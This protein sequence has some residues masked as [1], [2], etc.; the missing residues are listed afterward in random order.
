MT[1][2]PFTEEAE[3]LRFVPCWLHA[4]LKMA[5]RQ[6][7]K[8]QHNRKYL[9]NSATQEISCEFGYLSATC[10]SAR[11]RFLS[12]I[13]GANHNARIVPRLRCRI[14]DA[15]V[16]QSPASGGVGNRADDF[17]LQRATSGGGISRPSAFALGS[18]S[19]LYSRT[20]RS[21]DGQAIEHRQAH[22]LLLAGFAFDFTRKIT[23]PLSADN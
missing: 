10:R 23:T 2:L 19:A 11:A 18:Q 1:L 8:R 4:N 7:N 5:A 12:P 14:P 22:R 3:W 9:A 20:A 13:D 16:D 6:W 17:H 15:T 21:S